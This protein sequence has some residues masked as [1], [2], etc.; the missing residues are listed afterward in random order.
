MNQLLPIIADGS[1][2]SISKLYPSWAD[3]LEAYKG[4]A[5][6]RQALLTIAEEAK[7][8]GI[9]QDNELAMVAYDAATL[10]DEEERLL[11]VADVER[12]FAEYAAKEE[13]HDRCADYERRTGKPWESGPLWEVAYG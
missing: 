1:P 6:E 12:I 3:R 2:K 13:F 7:A 9:H 10:A 5:Y 11:M 8:E 4:T